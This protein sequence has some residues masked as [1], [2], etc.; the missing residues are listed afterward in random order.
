MKKN[1]GPHGFTGE[2]YQTF[3][4]K[5]IPIFYKL[6]QKLEEEGILPNSFYKTTITL[7]SKL[8]KDTTRKE[9]RFTS[10]MN[11]DAE[12]LSKIL[13]N[14][15]QQHIKEIYIRHDQEGFI[16]RKQSWFN[17]QI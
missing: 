9:L 15:I 1:P 16:S 10:L 5:L 2:F 4:E 3:Q 13:A 14:R 12:I 8:D 17:I 6:F 11:V 7:I